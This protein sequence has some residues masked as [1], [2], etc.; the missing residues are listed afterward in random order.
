MNTESKACCLFTTHE[1]RSW[2]G[3]PAWTL[4]THE[5]EPEWV[6]SRFP[7]TRLPGVSCPWR[8]RNSRVWWEPSSH[9]HASF[10]HGPFL[11]TA[12]VE[13]TTNHG[14]RLRCIH[15]STEETSWTLLE[16]VFYPQKQARQP[17]GP[18]WKD[19]PAPLQGNSQISPSS[20]L[21]IGHSAVS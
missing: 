13:V 12:G 6:S 8:H 16:L 4:L 11:A 5:D 1:F 9:P 21:L 18:E 20:I 15:S 7:A 3:P 2:L 10:C 19:D 17:F 14:Q